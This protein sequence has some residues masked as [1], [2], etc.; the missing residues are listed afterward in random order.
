MLVWAHRWPV[1]A[2]AGIGLAW[3]VSMRAWMRFITTDPEFTWGGTLAILGA[4]TVVGALL[5]LA[6]L[7]RRA[8]GA[9]WWRLSGLSLGLLGAGGAVMWPS[10]VL[11]AMALGRPRPSWIRVL[12]GLAAVAAQVPVLGDAVFANPGLSGLESA[13]AVAWYTPMIT[14]QAWAFSVV[15]APLAEAAPVAGP[16][17]RVALVTPAAAMVLGAALVAGLPGM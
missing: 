6:R 10:A 7:R 8:G 3:A 14:L 9:G 1:V 17:K 5:G 11:G 2:G 4:S 16:L 12:L 13:A 15:F